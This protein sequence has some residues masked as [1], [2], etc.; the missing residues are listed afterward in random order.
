MSSQD[1]NKELHEGA[2]VDARCGDIEAEAEYQA[3]MAGLERQKD[4]DQKHTDEK[5]T[6]KTE[7][8]VQE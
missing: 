3:K 2:D 1:K 7:A 4:T 6:D 8:K 5:H